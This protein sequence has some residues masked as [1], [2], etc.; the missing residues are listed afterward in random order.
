MGMIRKFTS[1][2][3]MGLVNFRSTRE[4][5]V[6]YLRRIARTV[7]AQERQERREQKAEE[8]R[9]AMAPP[10]AGWYEVGGHMRYWD[11]FRWTGRWAA[12]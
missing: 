2:S 9:L 4:R 1:L 8:L 6:A 7:A 12:R 5:E 11:G 10:P 3:T